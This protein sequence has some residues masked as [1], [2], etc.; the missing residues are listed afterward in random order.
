M[1]AMTSRTYSNAL[2]GQTPLRGVGKGAHPRSTGTTRP[3]STRRTSSRRSVA[4]AGHGTTIKQLGRIRVITPRRNMNTRPTPIGWTSRTATATMSRFTLSTRSSCTATVGLSRSIRAAN[5][6]LP[7]WIADDRQVC[8]RIPQPK[9]EPRCRLHQVHLP[10]R[11]PHQRA[12]SMWMSAGSRSYNS[13]L[14]RS[15]KR[16]PWLV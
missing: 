4:T 6:Q 2:G 12:R 9:E 7:P 3:I 15:A 16:N 8:V 13:W 11:P 14:T 5:H 10:G 1:G